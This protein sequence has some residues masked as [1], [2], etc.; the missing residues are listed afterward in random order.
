VFVSH[1][2]RSTMESKSLRFLPVS[3][4]L[5]YFTE[6]RRANDNGRSSKRMENMHGYM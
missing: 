3:V 6:E 5:Y 2:F 1:Y 4:H